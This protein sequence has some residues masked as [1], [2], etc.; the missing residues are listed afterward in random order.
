MTPIKLL[1]EYLADVKAQEKEAQLWGAEEEVKKISL[2]KKQFQSAID[3]INKHVDFKFIKEDKLLLKFGDQLINR[4]NNE[5]HKKKISRTKVAKDLN[6]N[7]TLL[8]RNLTKQSQISF[9]NYIRIC[10]Y[11]NIKR[12]EF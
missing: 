3:I 11:L 1:E 6:I 9:D 7:Y 12:Y 2:V 10:E 4:I 8:T 5:L